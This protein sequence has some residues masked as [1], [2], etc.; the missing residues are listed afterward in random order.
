MFPVHRVPEPRLSHV[1]RAQSSTI[2]PQSCGQSTGFCD[3]TP[4]NFPGHRVPESSL[5]HFA[6]PQGSR[7]HRCHFPRSQGS[8]I[9]PQSCCQATGFQNQASVL[10]PGHRVPESNRSSVPRPQVSRIHR[11]HIP[12]IQGSRINPQLCSHATGF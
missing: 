7:I 6:R 9:K 5:S 8:R 11:C 3:Q 12:R 10:L 1:P 4:V 2:K